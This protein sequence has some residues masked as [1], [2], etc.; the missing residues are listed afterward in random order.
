[1]WR[2]RSS[3]DL[4]F[5]K[6]DG[7][8]LPKLF[9]RHLQRV[10]Q[11]Q[12]RRL[13]RQRN[14]G[15]IQRRRRLRRRPADAAELALPSPQP[16]RR[17]SLRL[18]GQRYDAGVRTQAVQAT[19]LHLFVAS[20]LADHCRHRPHDPEQRRGHQVSRRLGNRPKRVLPLH[21]Q[22]SGRVR[23]QRRHLRH[24]RDAEP[25]ADVG[26]VVQ[27]RRTVRQDSP[28][29]PQSSPNVRRIL[30][31]MRPQGVNTIKLFYSSLTL[32]S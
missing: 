32:I 13:R 14:V 10:R 18:Q 15:A 7:L 24:R 22:T 16:A 4:P 1:M 27:R 20:R 5:L 2:Q 31:P 17:H 11:V 30:R 3:A 9:Q 26:D 8:K 6:P 12:L 23:R 21:L 28:S 19:R 25:V 29:A